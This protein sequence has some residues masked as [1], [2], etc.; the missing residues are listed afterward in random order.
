[1][2]IFLFALF[3]ITSSI[4]IGK[5][6]NIFV[7]ILNKMPKKSISRFTIEFGENFENI[8]KFGENRRPISEKF[9]RNFLQLAKNIPVNF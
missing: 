6:F 5:F 9:R 1:M 2:K 3:L 8:L 7:N 4:L